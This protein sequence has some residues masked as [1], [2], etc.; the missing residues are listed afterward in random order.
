MNTS[1]KV[2]DNMDGTTTETRQKKVALSPQTTRDVI[3]FA[4]FF[5]ILAGLVGYDWRLAA[6][7]GGVLLIFVAAVG[8]LLS[9]RKGR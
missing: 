2:T 1:W 6:I 7:V 3:C 4:G 5:A 8:T 9:R